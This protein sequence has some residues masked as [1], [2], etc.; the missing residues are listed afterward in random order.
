MARVIEK[1]KVFRKDYDRLMDA[2]QFFSVC[3]GTDAESMAIEKLKNV[4]TD[5]QEKWGG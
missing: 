1:M 2:V 3:I 4:Y 5:N